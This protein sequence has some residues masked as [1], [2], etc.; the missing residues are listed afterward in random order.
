MSLIEACS[1][2]FGTGTK[3]SG[4]LLP[5]LGEHVGIIAKSGQIHSC[6]AGTDQHIRGC[7]NAETG[8]KVTGLTG[9][10]HGRT[11]SFRFLYPHYI[12]TAD[13]CQENCR[14]TQEVFAKSL[15]K[16]SLSGIIFYD[17]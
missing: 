13:P 4:S 11:P 10:Q 12:H 15:T 2:C 7:L 3:R 14:K 16:S 17:I 5:A 9:K 1:L 6:V 8:C